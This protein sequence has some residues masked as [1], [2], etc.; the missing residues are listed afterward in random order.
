MQVSPASNTNQLNEIQGQAPAS[1]NPP[2]PQK[3]DT[4]QLSQAAQSH[5]QSGDVDHDGDSH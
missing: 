3:A 1:K 2:S 4:V 5:L